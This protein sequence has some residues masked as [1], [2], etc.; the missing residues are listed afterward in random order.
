[1]QDMRRNN[2]HTGQVNTLARRES[3]CTF[4]EGVKF[5][6]KSITFTRQSH[7]LLH[8]A[9]TLDCSIRACLHGGGVPQIG[10]VSRLGGVTRLSI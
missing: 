4:N 8:L 9:K 3:D 5:L 2:L 7:L 10:E 6:I 1:M